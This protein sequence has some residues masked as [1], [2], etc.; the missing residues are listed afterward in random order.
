MRYFVVALVLA[1]AFAVSFFARADAPTGDALSYPNL[2]V[3]PPIEGRSS[4]S[5]EEV[6]KT[7]REI[8]S[9]TRANEWALMVSGIIMLGV[10]MVRRLRL[11]SKL[12][13][14]AVPWVSV[15]IGVAAVIADDLSTG[16]AITVG[17]LTQGA[18][19]GLAASGAWGLVGRHLPIVGKPPEPAKVSD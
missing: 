8:L 9:D 18:L 11:V 1:F 14:R 13:S 12:P 6:A 15:G 17:R 3:D 16:G 19:A 4:P 5:A 10:G 7:G 2:S